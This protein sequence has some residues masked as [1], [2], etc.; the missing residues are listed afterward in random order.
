MQLGEF[1]GQVGPMVSDMNVIIAKYL[2][3]IFCC[4]LYIGANHLVLLQGDAKNI[5]NIKL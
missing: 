1:K 5:Q 3:R 4:E 2:S